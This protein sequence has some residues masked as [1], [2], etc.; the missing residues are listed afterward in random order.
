[1]ADDQP[2]PLDNPL[3]VDGTIPGDIV[4]RESPRMRRDSEI[5]RLVDMTEAAEMLGVVRQRIWQ[6]IEEDELPAVMVGR[7]YVLREQV[8]LE[9]KAQMDLERARRDKQD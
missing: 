4:V 7:I 6:L 8:V 1:M 5:P 9:Y 2:A 3:A